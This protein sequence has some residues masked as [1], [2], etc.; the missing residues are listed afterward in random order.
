MKSFFLVLAVVMVTVNLT[1]Q[2]RTETGMYFVGFSDKTGSAGIL[3]NPGAYL[4]E[5]ALLRRARH[6]V[7]VTE[8]D[9]PLPGS[10]VNGVKATGVKLWLRSKW[11]NGVVVA[12]AGPQLDQ[13]RS[14]AYVD[15]V[16][17]VA[18]VQY[19]RLAEEPT[20]PSLDHPAPNIGTIPV[21]ENF[22]GYGWRNIEAM[23]GDSL[24]VWGFRGDGVTVGVLDGGFPNV[25]YKYFLG[26]EDEATIPANYDIVQQDS[27]AL[28][29]STHGATVL[30]TMA[31]FRPFLFVGTA[32]AA[33]YVLF[34]TEN[35][36]GEH[37]LEEINYAVA[38][39]IAD[40]AG[41]DIVN[42]SLGYTTFG[43]KGMN[44]VYEDLTGK[45]SPASI[46]ASLA[47]ER[48]MIVVT[49]AGNSGSDPWKFIS[50]PADAENIFAIGALNSDGSRAYF[51]SIGPTPDGRIKPDVSALGVEVTAMTA[52]GRGVTGANGTSLASPLVTGLLACLIQAVP[53]ATN[54]EI[55]DAVRATADQAAAPDNERGYGQP[56]FAAAYRYLMQ[57]RK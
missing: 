40:S 6:G 49:S 50:V 7:T 38:L 52:S 31:T 46:A 57:A 17:Y 18:P 54:R 44:Y 41:V 36:E 14:L 26:Y 43:E 22:Y 5:K 24:H 9:L 27:T 53:G 29:G 21:N 20:I 55:L 3:D 12:A 15:T 8:T 35:S 4:S 56:N 47:F 1:A 33:R 51:S 34:T 10:Y 2:D 48:G 39:E 11:M 45:K 19:D 28:D 30:S 16:Y 23:K 37:R 25:G 32:P 42:S 13:L